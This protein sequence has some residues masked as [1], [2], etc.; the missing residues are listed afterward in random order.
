MSVMN[1]AHNINLYVN[2]IFCFTPAFGDQGYISQSKIQCSLKNSPDT[3]LYVSVFYYFH[4]CLHTLYFIPKSPCLHSGERYFCWDWL[5]TGMVLSTVACVL[6]YQLVFKTTLTDLSNGQYV[7]ATPQLK[8]SYNDS[9]LCQICIK[10]SRT[11]EMLL[12]WC[13]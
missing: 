11:V 9:R 4:S 12:C 2:V 6:L 8:L 3:I 1:A 13:L 10:L 7:L 5:P